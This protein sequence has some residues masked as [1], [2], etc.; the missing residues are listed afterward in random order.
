MAETILVGKFHCGACPVGCGRI[1]KVDDGPYA[2]V[3]GAG[4][5]YETLAALGSLCMVDDLNSIA[6]ANQLCNKYGIDTMSTGST[7]AFAIEAF[8]RGIIT[9]ADADGLEL[10]WG[11]PSCIIS[12]IHKIGKREGFGD[13]LG[14]GSKVAAERI[15]KNAQELTVEIKGLEM[16]FH[17]PRSLVSTAVAYA[18]HP[19]GGCHRGCTHGLERYAL[20]ELG[21]E[22]PMDRLQVEGKAEMVVKMQDYAGLFNSLKLCQIILS[23]LKPSQVVK[24]LNYVT[25]WDMD[26]K[27]LLLAGERATN[28]KRLY[29]VRLGLSRKDDTLP[30]RILTQPMKDGG[31]PNYVPHL[32]KM[33]GEYY[34]YR[35]WSEEGIP[36][37]EKLR[38]LGLEREIAIVK[39]FYP[40]LS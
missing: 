39:E 8:E 23:A 24:F 31:S 30:L 3:D 32:G 11:D 9:K 20:P 33:L 19:R 34:G 25:G 2:G 22:K 5:E 40:N 37:P 14:E 35:G 18:T 4:P 36:L 38:E 27:E 12:L 29:N 1:V 15:G 7:I 16:P 21:Y 17:D 28:L 6:Y 10:R 13:L 26:L